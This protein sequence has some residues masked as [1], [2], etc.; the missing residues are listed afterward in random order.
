MSRFSKKYIPPFGTS[1]SV[2]D[3]SVQDNYFILQVFLYYELTLKGKDKWTYLKNNYLKVVHM[4]NSS[5][6]LSPSKLFGFHYFGLVWSTEFQNII[7]FCL[8]FPAKNTFGLVISIEVP[9]DLLLHYV[10]LMFH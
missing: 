9:I 8:S 3:F 4:L 6:S 7:N 2:Q 10:K 5:D 1:I